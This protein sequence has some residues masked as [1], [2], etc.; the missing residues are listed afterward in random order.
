MNA[1]KQQLYGNQR[2]GF[3]AM[4]DLMKTAKLG[5]WSLMTIIPAYFAPTTE[6]FVK[7][8]TAK[9]VLKYFEIEDPIYKP[10]PTWE[11]YEKYREMI[12]VSKSQVNKNLSPSNAAFSGF[13]MMTVGK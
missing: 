1:F 5:K 12:N 13:L 6:V 9:N 2:A 10:T 3:E 4:V 8:T 7:P 11:F